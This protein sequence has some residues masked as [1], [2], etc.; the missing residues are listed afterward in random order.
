VA[1][2]GLRRVAATP[3]GVDGRIDDPNAGWKC[4]G[5]WSTY[6]GAPSITS[7]GQTSRAVGAARPT[8]RGREPPQQTAGNGIV[9][10][11]SFDPQTGRLTRIQ[12]GNGSVGVS[13]TKTFAYD[14]VGNLLSK[15][16]V[17]A[18]SYPAPGQPRPH[19]VLSISG[20][21]LNTTFTYDPNGNM[22]SGAGRTFGCTSYNKPASISRGATTL[23]FDHDPEHQRYRQ[24]GP[25]A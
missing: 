5:I 7:R 8:I 15:T 4:K 21:T 19:G 1:L 14:P 22:T 23:Q 20:D 25:A 9:T 2:E 10:T 17:G 12:A 6:A 13:L 11:Q 16:G 24:L 18:Y 3:K